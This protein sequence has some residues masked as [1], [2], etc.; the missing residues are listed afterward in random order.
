MKKGQRGPLLLLGI[1]HMVIFAK[2]ERILLFSLRASHV[3]KYKI[4]REI[5]ETLT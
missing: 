3:Y 5:G 1:K 2:N 4:K